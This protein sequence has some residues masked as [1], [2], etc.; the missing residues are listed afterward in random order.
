MEELRQDLV[1]YFTILAG[2]HP[3]LGISIGVN[4]RICV[5]EL[6][7]GYRPYGPPYL[8]EVPAVQFRER[9]K[10]ICK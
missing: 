1:R 5:M 10:H 4:L 2:N 6:K 3:D 8:G 9:K 7:F